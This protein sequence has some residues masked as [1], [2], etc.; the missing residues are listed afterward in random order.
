MRATNFPGK[1]TFVNGL[2]DC[3]EHMNFLEHIKRDRVYP[4]V[5]E[6]NRRTFRQQTGAE[7]KSAAMSFLENALA[8]FDAAAAR[9]IVDPV[10][11]RDGISKIIDGTVDCFNASAWVKEPVQPAVIS[12][13]P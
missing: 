1:N 9:D 7:K 2:N 12:P 4:S 6:R 10:K 13:Q 5:G 8:M 11:F 3:G